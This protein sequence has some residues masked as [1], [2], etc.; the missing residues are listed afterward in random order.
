MVRVH[1]GA[2]RRGAGNSDEQSRRAKS[3]REMERAREIPY[4]NARLG[5]STETATARRWLRSTM[6]A[7][8]LHV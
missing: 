5:I 2:A 7:S 4:L 1:S 6:A 8:G 3:K